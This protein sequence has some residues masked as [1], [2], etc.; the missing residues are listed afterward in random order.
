MSEDEEGY[1]IVDKRYSADSGDGQDGEEPAAEVK[2]IEQNEEPAPSIG[3][4]ETVQS[5]QPEAQAVAD[6]FSIAKWVIGIMAATAWQYMG[7]QVNPATGKVEK[8]LIQAR[9]AVDTVVF[10]G[11]KIHPHLSESERREIR[12]L[13]GD[14]QVNFVRQSESPGSEQ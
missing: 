8:D 10:L 13:I 14:L 6:V 12:S 1:R 3:D 5:E 11:D 2:E 4:E 7:L 9:I